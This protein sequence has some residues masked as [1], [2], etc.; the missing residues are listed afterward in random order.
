[1]KHIPRILIAVASLSA[2]AAG[3]G[4]KRCGSQG[5][6]RVE[7][8][9]GGGRS[10]VLYTDSSIAD[11][12]ARLYYVVCDGRRELVPPTFLHSVRWEDEDAAVNA[13]AYD[14]VTSRDGSVAAVANRKAPRELIV[15]QDFSSG[16]SWP[17]AS[18]GAADREAVERRE[19]AARARLEADHPEIHVPT[20]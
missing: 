9:A 6:A 13:T 7:F 8:E 2:G 14:F 10:I 15:L 12:A 17:R 20:R 18:Y 19:S 3:A 1:V 16:E 11:T 4:C 5:H